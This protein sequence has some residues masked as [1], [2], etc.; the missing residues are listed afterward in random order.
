MTLTSEQL[1]ILESSREVRFQQNGV[2]FVV[3]RSDELQRLRQ[4]A[5]DDHDELRRRLAESSAANGWEEPGMDAYDA[6]GTRS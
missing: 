4:E 1:Q 5:S 2:E 3:L 6:Y